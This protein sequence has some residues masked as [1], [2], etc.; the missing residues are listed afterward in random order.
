MSNLSLVHWVGYHDPTWEPVG[1][2]TNCAEKLK[3]FWHFKQMECP[4]PILGLDCSCFPRREVSK[5][6]IS[7]TTVTDTILGYM[8]SVQILEKLL[9]LVA[10]G[11]ASPA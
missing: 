3:E 4:H 2:L 7:V 5:G 10:R 8:G 1:H 9:V 11:F 6:G